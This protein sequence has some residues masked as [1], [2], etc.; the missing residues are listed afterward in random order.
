MACIVEKA[1]EVVGGEA[2]IDD[3]TTI[4]HITRV[5]ALGKCITSESP[6]Q[7]LQFCA[8]CK[9]VKYCCRDHQIEHFKEGGHKLV[10]KGRKNAANTSAVFKDFDKKAKDAI[11]V[12]DWKNALIGYSAML[13]LTEKGRDIVSNVIC[14]GDSFGVCLCDKTQP[15]Y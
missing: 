7:K 3:G 12:M 14:E 4:G 13:E 9:E 10:C 8:A 11:A 2:V 6:Q 15:S 1:V 5:C